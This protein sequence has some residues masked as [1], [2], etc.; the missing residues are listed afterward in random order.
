MLF[1]KHSVLSWE[2]DK[3]GI[4]FKVLFGSDYVQYSQWALNT[5]VLPDKRIAHISSLKCLVE[6]GSA[7]LI[8]EKSVYVPFHIAAKFKT[9]EISGLGLPRVA[10]FSITLPKSKEIITDDEFRFKYRLYN[11]NG[12][13]VYAKDRKGIIIQVGECEYTLL[14]P[15]YS[16]IE[17]IEKF[18]YADK[19]NLDEK[20]RLLGKIKEL[21]PTDSK[22]DPHLQ[23]INVV[24]PEG[25]TI[26]PFINDDGE[27]DFDPIP[28]FYRSQP[29]EYHPFQSNEVEEPIPPAYQEKFASNYRNRRIVQPRYAAGGS[30]YVFLSEPIQ[31]ALDI[32]HRLQ[33]D[34]VEKRKAFIQ[35]PRT[36]LRDELGEEYNEEEIEVLF[37]DRGYSDRVKEVGLWKP[38]IIPF[39]K[40]GKEPWL[41][42]EYSGIRIDNNI[43]LV[44]PEEIPELREKVLKAIENKEDTVTHLSETIPANKDTL[45]TL[46]TLE[47][48]SQ[49][50]KSKEAKAE[51][52][53]KDKHV[54]II[55]DGIDSLYSQSQNESRS[56]EEVSIEHRLKFNPYPHQT[57]A[58]A[59]LK[60]HWIAGNSGALLADDMG[61]GKTFTT[62]AFMAWV[63]EKMKL[64][65]SS[66]KPFL[67]V[68]PTGLL[69]N[70]QDEH[71]Q[72]LE[73]NG[74]GMPLLAYGNQLKE[75]KNKKNSNSKEL[76][77]GIP[78]LDTIR[79]ESASWVL[80]T[81]ETLRD[82]QHS[83]G[84][85]SWSVAIFDEAQKI[86]NPQAAL[87]QAAK[88][89]KMD[90]SIAVTGTPV[91]NR[92]ADMW[93]IVDTVQPGKLDSLKSFVSLYEKSKDI[94]ESAKLLNQRLT[95]DDIPPLMKRRMKIDQLTDLCP[96]TTHPIRIKMP[97]SQAKAYKEMVDLAISQKGEKGIML[98]TLGKLRSISLHPSI[99]RANE[100][101]NDYIGK[102]ARLI[103][104]FD[105][106]KGIKKK[107]EKVL[108]FVELRDMQGV[109]CELL[110]RRFKLANPPLIIN[111]AISGE[112]R[113]NICD[114]FKDRAGFDVMLLSPKAGGVGLTITAAN[115]VIHLS[116]WW[117]PAVEDQCTDRVYRIGQEKEVHVYYP[118]AIH[119]EFEDF[120]F[121]VKLDALLKNKSMISSTATAPTAFSN[122]DTKSLYSD[123][124][125][126]NA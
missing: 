36:F 46:D 34:S 39:I 65:A 70:W 5:V 99:L 123:T 19:T 98:K 83:F 124:V 3:N 13:P 113:K 29:D 72:S 35:S 28:V 42:P 61:L 16:I 43:V 54:L 93:C 86:K 78:S 11:S 52:E 85:I 81:Y 107:K 48:A 108:V 47:K 41:P 103:A 122:D 115:H 104:L 76:D 21:L 106:L 77:T 100:S 22:V 31:K 17:D 66:C 63:Q 67:I 69:K 79:L 91:E 59:W 111:G 26:Q 57:K 68:A 90:F 6:E 49:Q 14:D 109:L 88:A 60:E 84:K 96:I 102:S 89:M 120:S 10:P 73:N 40:N 24:F 62:L 9:S 4:T 94:Q 71:N 55:E 58:I 15:I 80:T 112:K 44:E 126:K 37:S 27:P 50:H 121:D 82:Y 97:S 51:D 7:I 75:L 1:K 12:R 32:V 64:S 118:L 92:L 8:E 38:T 105:I 110:Q 2:Q 18:S 56:H 119:P 114:I 25:F 20:F 30:W 101:D 117:N 45:N 87:T 95:V 125:L 23:D 74:L 116:R 53:T 33:N